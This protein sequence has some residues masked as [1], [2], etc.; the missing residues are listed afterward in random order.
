MTVSQQLRQWLTQWA[1]VATVALWKTDGWTQQTRPQLRPRR[2]LL[3]K[4]LDVVANGVAGDGCGAAVVVAG[5]AAAVAADDCGE[6]QQRLQRKCLLDYV[7]VDDV[8]AVDGGAAA[9][10]AVVAGVGVAATTSR[11]TWTTTSRH[12]HRRAVVNDGACGARDRNHC[13]GDFRCY[14]YFGGHEYGGDAITNGVCYAAA[15]VDAVGA[16]DAYY[17]RNPSQPPWTTT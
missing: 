16:D 5:V 9:A 12:R 1:A 10:G 4:T 17:H 13:R 6:R 8:V 7:A 2:P 15:V 14:D 11:P 3:L